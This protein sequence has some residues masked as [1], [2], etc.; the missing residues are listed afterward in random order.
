MAAAPAKPAKA[1]KPA[2]PPHGAP[3]HVHGDEADGDGADD[4][5]QLAAQF[6]LVQRELQRVDRRLQ[7]LEEA[8]VEAQQAAAALRSMAEAK[9]EQDILLPLGAGVHIAAR[10]DGAQPVLMPL[11]AGYF[12]EDKAAGV[13]DALDERVK[14]IGA[15]FQDASSQAEQLAQ[16]AAQINERL[17]QFPQ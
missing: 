12:T 17:S 1:A 5:R 14:A 2:N 13:A 7:A 3:G 11:G 9:G 4:P 15:Q 6:D 8:L 10:V 16:V